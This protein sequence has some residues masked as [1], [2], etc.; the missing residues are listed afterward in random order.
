MSRIPLST[1]IE[2]DGP[3]CIWPQCE[4][5]AIEVSHFH[6]KGKGGTPNG[7]RDALENL[8]GMCWAHARMSDGERP[9]GWPAYKKA[10]TLLFGEGWEERIPMGS[11]AYE[12]A[13]AL[14]R[15]VA[16]RRS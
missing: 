4:I 1:L 11:W 9:G 14:R 12:R 2:L 15:I 5:P 8:G 10:H 6:S 13:E 16:G 7:R 3:Q